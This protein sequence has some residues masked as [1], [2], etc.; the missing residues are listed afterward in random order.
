VV[1]GVGARCLRRARSVAGSGAIS[2]S[3]VNQ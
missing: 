1:S 3:I 2:L